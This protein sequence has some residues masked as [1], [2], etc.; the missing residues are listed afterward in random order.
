MDD[1]LSVP[2]AAVLLGV[3]EETVRRMYDA[4]ELT[5]YRT[6]LD[7]GWRRIYRSSVDAA[8]RRRAGPPSE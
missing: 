8:L 6:R 7:G 2:Q 5:G 1:E 3:S 4:G